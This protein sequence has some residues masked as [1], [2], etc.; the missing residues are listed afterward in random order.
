MFDYFQGGDDR[1]KQ[2]KFLI[3][4]ILL[5]MTLLHF[6]LKRF[7]KKSKVEVFRGN[8]IIRNTQ[9]L[10][11]AGAIFGSIGGGATMLANA[12]GPIAQL[13]L[14]VMGLPKYAFMVPRPGYF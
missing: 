3:G 1:V 4:L 8:A 2:L 11:L 14:L 13:Y 5:S 7:K 10:N 12:A 6:T 9:R